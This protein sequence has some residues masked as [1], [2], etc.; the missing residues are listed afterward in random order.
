MSRKIFTILTCI[1]IFGALNCEKEEKFQSCP[2][3][4]DIKKDCKDENVS[5][6]VAMHPQCPD[7]ICL[8]YKFKDITTGDLWLSEPFCTFECSAA[9]DCTED[10]SCLDYLDKKYCIPNKY[11]QPK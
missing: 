5:C 1:L 8:I 7:D 2:M 11:L 4:E 9:T 3:T 6:A 10:S